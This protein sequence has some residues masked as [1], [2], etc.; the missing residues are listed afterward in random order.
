M[1]QY[2]KFLATYVAAVASVFAVYDATKGLDV[3]PGLKALGFFAVLLIV[4]LIVVAVLI[5]TA[6]SKAE[7]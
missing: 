2:L 4:F 6:E 7:D 3:S 5:Y 1:T